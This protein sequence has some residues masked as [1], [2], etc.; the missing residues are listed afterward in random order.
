MSEKPGF[1]TRAGV[2][3]Q[4]GDQLIKNDGIALLELIKNAYD[5]DASYCRVSMKGIDKK[6]EGAIEILDDGE[7]MNNEILSQAW[8]EIGTSYKEKLAEHEETRRTKKFKRLRLGEKGIGRIGAHRLGRKIKIITRQ[9]RCRE[10]ILKLDWDNIENHEYVEDIPV[11]IEDRVPEKFTGERRGT[12]VR[13]SANRNSWTR[14]M[15]RE[16][17]RT[18]L[19]LNSP[20]DSL[21]S[22]RVDYE[23]D[24]QEWLDGLLDFEDI[25]SHKLFSFSVIMEGNHITDFKYE[26]LPWQTMKN[27]KYRK[28]THKDKNMRKLLRMVCEDGKDFKDIDLAQYDIG[29]IVF[30]GIIFDLDSR[31]LNLGVQDKPG[32]KKYLRENGGIRVFRDN[33]RVLDYG[34]P[35]ND[36]LD[37]GGRRVN[38]P[39]KRI[40]NHIILGAVY[41][42]REQS[43]DLLE[44]ANREGFI[45]NDAYWEL[46]KAVRFAID[47]IESCRKTDKD[48]LRK[49]YGPQKISEPVITSVTEL[50][51]VLERNVNDESLRKE[52]NRFLSIVEKE[53]EQITETLIKSAGAGLNLIMVIH[54]I[55]KIIKDAKM[56]L[57]K[58]SPYKMIRERVEVLSSLIEGYSILIKKSEKKVRNLKSIIEQAVFNVAFRLEAHNITLEDAYQKCLENICGVLKVTR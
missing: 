41:I 18:V 43:S 27:L 6:G 31:V 35:G 1:K 5:A 9:K 17:Y 56:M 29:K 44:K 2:I 45:E 47:R 23:L 42:D 15:V 32:L 52:I 57:R 54:Q 21:D 10:Y 20:F 38:I 22:F 26:F 46:V 39:A 49:Y 36:W 55:E 25:Q 28:I 4:L 3:N 11:N 51:E 53:Y 40:S 33:M 12:L 58:K 13:I 34:D 8:L 48:L 16:C 14:K 19:S 7:G 50:R 37:L 30:K 24:R